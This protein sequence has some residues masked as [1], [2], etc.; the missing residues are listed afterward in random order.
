MPRA[1]AGRRAAPVHLHNEGAPGA[2]AVVE[3]EGAGQARRAA[4]EATQIV[5][6][7]AEPPPERRRQFRTAEPWRHPYSTGT[8]GLPP[9]SSWCRYSAMPYPVC[10][11]P[12]GSR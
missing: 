5:H 2:V 4:G 3:L 1:S 7:A 10:G 9:P 8:T 6:A 12:L 11:A